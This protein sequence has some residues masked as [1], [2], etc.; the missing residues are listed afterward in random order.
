MKYKI[1]IGECNF[2]VENKGQTIEWQGNIV[3]LDIIKTAQNEFHLVIENRSYTIEVLEYLH[4]LKEYILKINGKKT[5]VKLQDEFDLLLA[6]MG[7]QGSKIK[8]N[9]E[10]KAP[11][12]GLVVEIAVEVGASIKKGEA[13]VI[14]EAMKMENVLKASSD[15]I[16]KSI[17]VKK[18]N[19][20]EKNQLLITYQ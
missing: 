7:M 13:L 5:Q 14:L 6:G 9:K 11:M 4:D 17:E 2:E 15:V 10:L 20:V 12:P 3:P 18:G 1:Q 8:L 16:I 19:A